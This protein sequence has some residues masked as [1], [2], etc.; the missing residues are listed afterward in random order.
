MRLK[1]IVGSPHVNGRTK[2]SAFLPHH[3][4]AENHTQ[5]I[6]TLISIA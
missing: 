2:I 3:Q 5:W 4:R 1:F 6:S